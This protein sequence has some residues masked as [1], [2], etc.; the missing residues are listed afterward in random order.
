MPEPRPHRF[1]LVV[2]TPVYNE[3]STLNSY[4]EQVSRVL[5]SRSDVD[6]CILFVDDGSSDGSWDLIQ[7]A[8]DNG[9]FASIRLSR[10]FGPHVALAAGFDHIPAD[11]HAIATL[12]VDLQDPPETIL[13]FIDEWRKGA[14]I[15]WGSRRSRADHGL[16]RTASRVFEIVLRWYAMP[17]DS[18]FQ[19]GSFFLIDRA[20]LD[21]VR[22]MREHGRVTFALVAWTG[23]N[24]TVVAYDRRQR[25]AGR[26]G[27]TPA[28]MLSTAYDVLIGFSPLPAKLFTRLG[29]ILLFGS[30]LTLIYLV[31]TWLS[32]DVQPGWTGLMAT[33]ILCFGLLFVM[34][35]IS[36][37][38]LYRI[39]IETKGRP[40]YFVSQRSAD[41]HR[42]GLPG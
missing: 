36:F 17:A 38:Y 21:C 4:V 15:V 5:L 16:R 14:D 31:I 10:N 19:T 6:I 28:Q 42:R 20:V 33:M 18:K 27:W 32:R 24:Q 12:A 29:I 3:E 25:K 1:K 37:E 26:S 7:R 8:T 2:V 34:L 11:A 9:R 41:V 39:F 22:L 30:I 35:G 13:E 40:L 23:F